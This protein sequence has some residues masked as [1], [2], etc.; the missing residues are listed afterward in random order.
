[1]KV[2]YVYIIFNERKEENV[3]NIKKFVWYL[4]IYVE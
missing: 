4:F 1:M 3:M 2:V